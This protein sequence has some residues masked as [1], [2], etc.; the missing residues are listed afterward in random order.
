[1]KSVT[2]K[3]FSFSDTGTPGYYSTREV[4]KGA[5]YLVDSYKMLIDGIAK[6]GFRNPQ[7]SLMYRGQNNDF[8]D[9]NGSSLFPSIWRFA[10]KERKK[11]WDDLN[12]AE[13]LLLN[14]DS[15]HRN[16]VRFLKTLRERTWAIL[17]HYGIHTPLLDLTQNVR[18]AATFAI[19]NYE[20]GNHDNPNSNGFVYVFGMPNLYQ[21]TTISLDD[22]LIL[23]RLQSVCPESAK[24]PH[25]QSGF[26]AGSYPNYNST[27]SPY[28]NF[29]MRLI[30]KFKLPVNDK[31]WDIDHPLPRVAVYPDQDGFL[32]EV[33]RIKK[34]V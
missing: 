33:K 12:A 29:S 7:F 18:V 4:A 22:G 17:Q 30:A 14:S 32:E 27:K 1:M 24:R 6:I 15:L 13:A 31:F 8:Q 16:E 11:R 5:G 19:K 34:T 28:K 3:I 9:K 21:G 20:N 26:L 25:L 2:K 10:P 23:L